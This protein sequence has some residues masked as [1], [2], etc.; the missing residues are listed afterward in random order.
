MKRMQVEMGTREVLPLEDKELLAEVIR[1]LSDS[2]RAVRVTERVF[3]NGAASTLTIFCADGDR[4]RVIGKRGQTIS[5][6]RYLFGSIGSLEDRHVTVR[7][8]G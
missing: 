6:L 1:A 2:P 4:G 5:A 8:D 3:A 7:V